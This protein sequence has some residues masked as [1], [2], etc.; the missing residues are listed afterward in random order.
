MK[1]E[2]HPAALQEYAEGVQFFAQQ[3]RHQDFIDTIALGAG[4]AN[5]NAIF[6]IIGAPERWPIVE[7]QI[8]RYRHV[9]TEDLGEVVTSA[10]LLK[11]SIADPARNQVARPRR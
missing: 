9:T 5:E 11:I 1:Y 3:D 2:F 10:E 7:G 6:K 4:F 8:R